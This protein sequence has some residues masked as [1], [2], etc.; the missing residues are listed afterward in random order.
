MVCKFGLILDR[1]LL[2]KIE[3]IDTKVPRNRMVSGRFVVFVR[4]KG[5][6]DAYRAI[7]WTRMPIASPI[8][9]AI[10]PKQDA[11]KSV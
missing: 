10:R 7:L 3:H 6:E 8:T 11:V 9:A 2:L 5:E 4:L 1:I